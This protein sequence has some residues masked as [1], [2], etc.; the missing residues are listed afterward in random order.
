MVC[1]SACLVCMTDADVP[2][3]RLQAGGIAAYYGDSVLIY[4]T[5]TRRYSRAGVMP[6]GLITSHCVNNV[7]HI[8][9]ALG[10]P[11]H[12]KQDCLSI[13]VYRP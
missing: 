5:Q 2:E 11:R 9:C 6:Y 10:E 7:T 8:I 12:G 1:V 13:L 3:F 4:D